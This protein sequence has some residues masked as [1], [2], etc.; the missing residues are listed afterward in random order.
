MIIEHDICALCGSKVFG[1]EQQNSDDDYIILNRSIE[2]YSGIPIKTSS[3]NKDYFLIPL[4]E[5][6]NIKACASHLIA[7]SYDCCIS[8]YDGLCEFWNSKSKELADIFPESTYGGVVL[9]VEGFCDSNLSETFKI[10]ARILGMIWNR[11]YT[12]EM[13]SSRTLSDMW[14]NRYF[15][16][17][18][19]YVNTKEVKGWLEEITTPSMR[20]YFALEPVNYEL[21][22]EY[23]Q[24]INSILE[25]SKNE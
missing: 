7:P 16:A 8:G 6:L 1:L 12:G 24:L 14:K 2:N 10:C 20:R 21:H 5:M 19:G 23:C 17:K 11:Y 25:E 3:D 9:D 18:D 22:N 13:L 15:K 4:D